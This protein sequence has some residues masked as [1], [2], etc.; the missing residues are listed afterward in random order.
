VKAINLTVMAEWMRNN[1]FVCPKMP[2]PSLKKDVCC[3]ISACYWY[4]H[5]PPWQLKYTQTS[6][7][8]FLFTKPYHHEKLST[9]AA[10]C[11]P[12]FYYTAFCFASNTIG[13][14]QLYS[15]QELPEYTLYC[16]GHREFCGYF[17]PGQVAR[18][19]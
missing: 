9:E 11:W 5:S 4:G 2:A 17:A 3:Y 13:I 14:H 19:L 1:L 6:G 7:F 10:Q 12:V 8:L 16:Y 18:Y 15:H